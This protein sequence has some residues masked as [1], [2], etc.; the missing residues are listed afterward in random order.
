[1]T[2]AGSTR[3][4]N[5][6]LSRPAPLGR[7]VTKGCQTIPIEQDQ[8]HSSLPQVPCSPPSHEGG[9]I[10]PMKK[11]TGRAITSGASTVARLSERM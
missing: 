5:V 1:M 7:H 10:R 2:F 11:R 8:L 9:G 6:Q 3:G 4:E